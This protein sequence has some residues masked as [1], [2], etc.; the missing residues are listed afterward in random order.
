[1]CS[2]T[3]TIGGQ[4]SAVELRDDFL[5]SNACP[6]RPS[7]REPGSELGT[8]S[9]DVAREPAAAWPRVPLERDIVAG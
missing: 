4:G 3:G 7:P 2:G 6:D 5:R 8:R 9:R 1:M